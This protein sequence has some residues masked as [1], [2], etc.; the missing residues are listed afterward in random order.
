MIFCR[1]L[2]IVRL[3][4]EFTVLSKKSERMYCN[5]L[6][7]IPRDFDLVRVRVRPLNLKLL[8][9]LLAS[10]EAGVKLEQYLN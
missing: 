4:A 7:L 9:L 2:K 3:T 1:L 8:K 6:F 10:Q 5:I